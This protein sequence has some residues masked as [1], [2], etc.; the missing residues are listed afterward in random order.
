VGIGRLRCLLLMFILFTDRSLVYYIRD[1]KN[2]SCTLTSHGW[3]L[4][5]VYLAWLLRGD[6]S[7]GLELPPLG[8]HSRCYAP[9]C[10][11]LLL[12]D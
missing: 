6:L 9:A 5:S 1:E 4:V 2:Q 7:S 10:W 3:P 11:S 8:G 12:M